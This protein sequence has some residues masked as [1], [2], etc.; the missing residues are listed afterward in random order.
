MIKT[1]ETMVTERLVINEL[2][3]TAPQTL[4]LK[5]DELEILERTEINQLLGVLENTEE[6]AA[7]FAE[8]CCRSISID[9]G[10]K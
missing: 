6:S 10:V 1:R 2:L 4:E 7:D 3:W 9:Y 5:L 8:I